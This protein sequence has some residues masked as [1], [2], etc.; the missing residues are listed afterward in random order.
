MLTYGR[1]VPLAELFARIDAVD[2]DTVKRVASR[3][4]YDKVSDSLELLEC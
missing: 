4:I 2:A 1:R 3:F